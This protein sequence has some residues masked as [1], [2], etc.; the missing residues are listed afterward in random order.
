MDTF[1]ELLE[2]ERVSVGRFVKFR[3]P[4]Q[5]DAEDVLQEVFLT[6]YQKFSQL[7]NRSA[8]KAWLLSIARNKCND[9]FR[10][11]AGQYE[12][13]LDMLSEKETADGRYGI[14]EEVNIKETIC[15]WKEMPQADI[16]RNLGIPLGTVKSRLH[17]AKQNFKE[18]YSYRTGKKGEKIMKKLPEQ[19]PE[20]RIEASTEP[21]FS[22]KWEELMGW[23]L[24]PR[25]GE[26]IS[27]GMYDMPS[28]KCIHV[29]DMEAVGRAKVHGIEGVEL[30][31]REAPYSSKK[32]TIQRTFIAQLTDT[33]CRYLATIRTDDG[34]RNYITFLDGDEFMLNWGF[35]EDNCGNETNLAPKG[36]ILRAGS[37]ITAANQDFLLDIVGRYTVSIQGKK[38]DTVCVMDL[39]AGSVITEQYLDHDGKTILWRR[40]NR[41]DWA[42]DRYKRKWS[43]QLPENERLTVNGDT[44]VHWYDCITDYIL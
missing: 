28:G 18:K 22:V 23:F 6:A 8:F 9:Y 33:H 27:W 10:R 17:T 34:I 43:E 39:S 1:E 41:D 31:A 35:G 21:V 26:K 38:F 29:Y 12:I 5:E 36:E 25:L 14:T 37:V 4:V 24:V 3:I 40:F 13:P 7:K 32:E 42:L 15:F 2:K 11:K 20:Y 16:A 30:I 19:M 44:F